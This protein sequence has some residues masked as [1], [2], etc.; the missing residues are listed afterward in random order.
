MTIQ[1]NKKFMLGKT[2]ECKAPLS[3]G[4]LFLGAFTTIRQFIESYGYPLVMEGI[5][6]AGTLLNYK[7][8]GN[9]KQDGTPTPD[10]PIEVQGVGV[11]TKNLL[12]SPIL[13]GQIDK[14]GVLQNLSSPS[15]RLRTNYIAVEPNTNYTMSFS[16]TTLKNL[17][18]A[19]YDEAYGLV[20]RVSGQKSGSSFTT[21]SNTKYVAFC[22]YYNDNVAATVDD[23]QNVQLEEG[24][25]ATSY[26]PYGYK[27]PVTASGKNLLEN[28]T[29]AT[30]SQLT[31]IFNY[32]FKPDTNYILSCTDELGNS[33][34]ET[35]VSPLYFKNS[36][37]GNVKVVA[38][39]K[40]FSLT[41]E[42]ISAITEVRI[43]WASSNYTGKGT[44]RRY[45][46]EEG[47]TATAYEAY[48]EPVTTNIYLD[49]PLYKLGD[50]AD[51]IDFGNK[52][53]VRNI[54]N[55]RISSSARKSKFSNSAQ[56]LS[57]WLFSQY[58]TITTFR[59][60]KSS[61]FKSSHQPY[62]G[63]AGINEIVV[64][65][66]QAKPA[67]CIT[68]DYNSELTDLDKFNSWL[69]SNDVEIYYPTQAPTT[70]TVD[71][72][73]LPVF[74]GTTIYTVDGLEPSDMYG[75]K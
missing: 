58:I 60:L 69:D 66:A 54:A 55:A 50:Y 46:L 33:I 27:I 45:Q 15:G 42:E 47:T 39:S 72:P 22:F 21:Q 4:K 13:N 14:S 2:P 24:T 61:H 25:T 29:L 7:V 8:W 43:G 74:E 32:D 3:F 28:S 19:Q 1:F 67:V 68:V 37:G 57:M 73:V 9:A 12:D 38:W 51:Y 36:S 40:S 26:E 53:V 16:V 35:C 18:I 31:F 10:T 20:S 64:Q 11:K 70:E 30:A 75:K 6:T 52:Q 44:Y 48:Q 5:K 23:V 17:I 62:W 71:L 34:P 63:T 49:K 41:A 59:D 56:T 65:G